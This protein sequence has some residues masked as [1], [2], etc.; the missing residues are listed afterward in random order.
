[1]LVT[2]GAGFIGPHLVEAL[3]GGVNGFLKTSHFWALRYMLPRLF[4]DLR[5]FRIYTFTLFARIFFEG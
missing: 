5:F 1:M 2:G 3:L 4:S